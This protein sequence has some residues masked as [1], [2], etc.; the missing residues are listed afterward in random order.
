MIYGGYGY[1]GELMVRE[2]VRRGLRPVIAGR[3]ASKLAL[4]ADELGLE[5]RAFEVSQ[6]SSQLRDI[7]VVLNC[8]GPF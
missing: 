5:Y 7:A 4:L 8:A 3:S 6:A 1:T 2:A